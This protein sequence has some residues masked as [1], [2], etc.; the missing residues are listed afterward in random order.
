[1]KIIK[2]NK[3]NDRAD[4]NIQTKKCCNI[5]I[6]WKVVAVAAILLFAIFIVSGIMKAH[7]FKPSFTKPTQEQIDY[8]TKLASDRLESTG[9]N[10]SDFKI[11]FGQGMRTPQPQNE[12]SKRTIIQVSFYN[13]VT[14]HI[15]LV[16]VNSGEVL[17]HSQTDI[18][19]PL[20]NPKKGFF[21]E[22]RSAEHSSLN[23]EIRCDNKERCD[24]NNERS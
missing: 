20:D 3:K 21:G 6:F 14:T 7:Y 9:A 5:S 22:L 15:Y 13:N 2:T 18:Y 4:K 12:K 11:K 23:T 8:A 19:I 16:D 24:Y 17:L 1:M 10:I